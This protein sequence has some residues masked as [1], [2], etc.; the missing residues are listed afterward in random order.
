M[1]TELLHIKT[2]ELLEFCKNNEN[3]VLGFN[4]SACLTNDNHEIR[5]V[6]YPADSEGNIDKN[7]YTEPLYFLLL[8]SN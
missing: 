5:I 4:R 6:L 7:S 1:K 3:A 8:E 2:S